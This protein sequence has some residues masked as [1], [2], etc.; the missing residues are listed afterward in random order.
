MTTLLD[1]ESTDAALHALIIGVGDYPHLPGGTGT[2][3]QADLGL[4]Q[5]STPV[6][7][8]LAVCAWASTEYGNAV[9]PLGSIELLISAQNPYDVPGGGDPVDRATEANVRDAAQRWLQRADRNPGNIA[10]FY[11]CGHGVEKDNQYLLLEDYGANRYQPTEASM[12]LN[13][14]HTGMLNCKAGTQLF[15]ADA[16][17]QVPWDLLKEIDPRGQTYITGNYQGNVDRDAPIM[18]ATGFGDES[19][20]DPGQS[21]RFTQALL[22]GLRGAAAQVDNDEPPWEIRWLRLAECVQTL[23]TAAAAGTTQRMVTSGQARNA[24]IAQLEEPPIVPLVV[25]CDPSASSASTALRLAGADD[26]Q[27]LFRRDPAD[28]P[29]SLQAPAVNYKLIA[30]ALSGARAA[31]RFL[32]LRPPGR[33]I[34]LKVTT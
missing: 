14:F 10:L 19:H 22:S 7:S 16:C 8:A 31:E 12:D 34:K 33:E 21:T 32:P 1:T 4:G 5:V 30:S 18:Y 28:G 9:A 23:L 29:W 6:P 3:T 15:F 11:F 24:L 26:G 25:I 2:T 17:R 20:A 27:V 13:G